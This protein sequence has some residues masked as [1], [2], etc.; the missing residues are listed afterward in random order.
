LNALPEA[1]DM[2]ISDGMDII[3]MSFN[4]L[5]SIIPKNLLVAF[6]KAAKL[7]IVIVSIVGN[8]D[9]DFIWNMHFPGDLPS[10]ISVD[11]ADTRQI[12]GRRFKA[13]LMRNPF[14]YDTICSNA[15]QLYIDIESG[16]TL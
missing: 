12:I 1:I 6:G 7:N 11:M 3:N 10:V 13:E 4:V 15:D 14:Y 2:A 9:H 5:D 16:I 8:G